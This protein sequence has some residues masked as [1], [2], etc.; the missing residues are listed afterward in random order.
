MATFDQIFA[1]KPVDEWRKEMKLPKNC[2]HAEI[3][4]A[5]IAYLNRLIRKGELKK[6]MVD[7]VFD[8]EVIE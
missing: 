4:G 8:Y 5:V 2:T 7:K 1:R 3:Q 6:T